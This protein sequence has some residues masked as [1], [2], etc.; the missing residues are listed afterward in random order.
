MKTFITITLALFGWTLLALSVVGILA[1]TASAAD[2]STITKQTD[3]LAGDARRDAAAT[4]SIIKAERTGLQGR[5]NE[6][7]SAAT[8][9]EKRVK[10]LEE[11]FE[12][13]KKREA[14]LRAE[15]DAQRSEI[16]GIEGA[17]RTHAK[18][19][20]ILLRS[21]PMAQSFPEAPGL[22][23]ALL[24]DKRFPGLEGI[25]GLSDLFLGI[26]AESGAISTTQGEFIGPDGRA[27]AGD[28]TRV[29]ALTA[30]YRIPG[31][32]TGY[33]RP[34]ADGTLAAVPG[35]P[36]GVAGDIAAFMR[37]EAGHV[38]LDISNG[39]AFQRMA[40][41]K[42]LGEWLTSGG[43]LVWPILLVG[44]IALVLGLERIITLSRVRSNSDKAF[45]EIITMADKGDWERCHTYCEDQDRFATCRVLHRALDNLGRSREVLERSLEEG[46]LH[47]LPRLERFLPTLSILAAIAP[48][49]GLLGTVTGMI[50]TFQVIT[51]H[52]TGDPR[53]M[54]GGISEALI[55]TQLGLAVAIPIMAVHHFLERRVDKILGDMEEKCT[56]FTVAMLKNGAVREGAFLH[57]A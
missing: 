8:A 29:G 57:A 38:P 50:D 12:A 25:R 23:A 24:D 18:E 15:L 4:R 43:L 49:L 33:L 26:M 7:E 11:R 37:G 55:T 30:M 35:T 20:D 51:L 9:A 22:L 47:E 27:A 28:V 31:G 5:I 32:E 53:M 19:A 6:V 14:A 52:G 13:M 44:A 39:A 42:S 46:L 34:G 48:L 17:V 45:A 41:S 3:K 10:A 40:R 16:K 21:G 54:S 36:W 56:A 1:L 2:L